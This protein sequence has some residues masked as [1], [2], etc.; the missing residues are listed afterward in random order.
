MR[1]FSARNSV[2]NKILA[3]VF[4]CEFCKFFK[5]TYFTEHLRRAGS[6][7]MIITKFVHKI[8]CS[9]KWKI[10]GYQR[11]FLKMSMYLFTIFNE[12]KDND[13]VA[14]VLTCLDTNS[15]FFLKKR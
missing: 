6:N 7:D 9:L 5:S 11:F 8:Y 15:R 1:N 14:T 12:S 10:K 4:S 3:Q 2:K 13:H